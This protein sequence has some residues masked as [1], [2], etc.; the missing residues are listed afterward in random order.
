LP[1]KI[2]KLAS[3]VNTNQLTDCINAAIFEN[4]FP[5]E[6]KLGDVSPVFKKD[7]STNKDNFRP[8]SVLSAISKIYERIL[9]DQISSYMEDILSPLTCVVFVRGIVPSTP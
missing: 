7:D 2:I 8:I 1:I 9:T 3:K 4:I 5:N 6:L